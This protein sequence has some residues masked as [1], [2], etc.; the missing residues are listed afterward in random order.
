MR[1]TC[2]W[3][4]LDDR[5]A[6]LFRRGQEEGDFRIDLSAAWLTEAFYGLIGAGCLGRVRRAGRP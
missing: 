4:E 6:A 5:I 3:A 2:G 1:S